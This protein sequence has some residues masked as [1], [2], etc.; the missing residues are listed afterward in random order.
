M[1]SLL[2]GVII[3]GLIILATQAFAKADPRKLAPMVKTAGGLATLGEEPR[4]GVSW[5]TRGVGHHDRDRPVRPGLCLREAHKRRRRKRA[6]GKLQDL[7]A[8]QVHPPRFPLAQSCRHPGPPFH[9]P[10]EPSYDGDA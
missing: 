4:N 8:A 1:G 3:L 7:A 10:E 5:P 9:G 2:F 6:R